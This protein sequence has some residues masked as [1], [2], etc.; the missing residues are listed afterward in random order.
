MCDTGQ[1]QQLEDICFDPDFN[2][3]FGGWNMVYR[4]VLFN[5][6]FIW[7]NYTKMQCTILCLAI[8]ILVIFNVHC[9]CRNCILD[10]LVV[11]TPRIFMFPL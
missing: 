4:Y 8:F 3:V 10:I 1:S 5:N 7:E 6:I 11:V 9:C 2:F